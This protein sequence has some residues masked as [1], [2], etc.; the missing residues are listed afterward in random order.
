MDCRAEVD[1]K[2]LLVEK[3]RGFGGFLCG[4]LALAARSCQPI[5][6]DW[7]LGWE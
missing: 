2:K 5:G 1:I 6:R 3:S 4:K 7:T